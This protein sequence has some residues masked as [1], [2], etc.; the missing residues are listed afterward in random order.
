[1]RSDIVLTI[2]AMAAATFLTRFTS[3]VLLGNVRIPVLMQ[4][5][6]RHVP[7]AMLTALIAPAL[8]APRGSVELSLQNYYLIA[9]LAAA[10]MAYRR[11]SPGV[12]MGVGMAVMLAL[13]SLPF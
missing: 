10:F 5:I 11:Q 12:T 8:L 1:M 9:G 4:R 2:I 7:T 13:R 6:L 3:P